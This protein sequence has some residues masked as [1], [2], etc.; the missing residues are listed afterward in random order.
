MKIFEKRLELVPEEKTPASAP[1]CAQAGVMEN[2]IFGIVNR[3]GSFS[4]H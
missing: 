2:L 3:M 4:R 1:W